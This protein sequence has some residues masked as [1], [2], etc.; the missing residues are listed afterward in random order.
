[1][2]PLSSVSYNSMGSFRKTWTGP[3][4][5]GL[6]DNVSNLIELEKDG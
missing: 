2:V 3:G 6:P 4:P 1:M 5:A